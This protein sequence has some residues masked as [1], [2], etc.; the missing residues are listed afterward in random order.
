[1]LVVQKIHLN[2]IR[3]WTCSFKFSHLPK[4]LFI[5]NK[6]LFSQNKL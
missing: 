1:M 3:Y 6:K 4:L 5:V 2:K